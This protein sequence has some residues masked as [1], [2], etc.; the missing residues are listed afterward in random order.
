MA[1][2][3]RK[4]LDND[5]PEQQPPTSPTQPTEDHE[6]DQLAQARARLGLGDAPLHSTVLWLPLDALVVQHEQAA[7]QGA[8]AFTD[9][10]SLVGVLHTP[11]VYPLPGDGDGL[12]QYAVAAGRRRV[13]AARAAG[14]TEIECRVYDEPLTPA[15]VALI[16]LSENLHR[17]PSWVEEVRA[18]A[19]L[20]GAQAALTEAEVAKVLGV[21]Q[22][23]VRERIK[24]ARLPKPFQDEIY[25]ERLSESAARQ[26]TRLSPARQRL[27]LDALERGEPLT[28]DVVKHA[29][30]D[31]LGVIAPSLDSALAVPTDPTEAAQAAVIAPPDATETGDTSDPAVV[32][33][34][35]VTETRTHLRTLTR[36]WTTQPGIYPARARM[37]AQALLAE[38]EQLSPDVLGTV[39]GGK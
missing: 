23:T 32:T 11:A 37:L 30:T 21:Q 35:A 34:Q 12:Q 6:P 33:R 38:L 39:E 1:T 26:I 3:S 8:K 27:L 10:M 24:L 2:K 14:K 25:A 16:R 15:Q 36:L 18:L 31:Q 5:E 19:E 28:P 4:P 22:Q 17:S 29:L 20:I 9:N 13:M 7:A